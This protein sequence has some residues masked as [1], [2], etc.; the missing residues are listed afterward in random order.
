MSCVSRFLTQVNLI[1]FKNVE[2][3]NLKRPKSFNDLNRLHLM[4]F[5]T[6]RD[7]HVLTHFNQHVGCTAI[8]HVTRSLDVS[9]DSF[10]ENSQFQ[11]ETFNRF[12]SHLDGARAFRFIDLDRKSFKTNQFIT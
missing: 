3:F 4:K 6:A 7:R 10:V 8:S 2:S 9:N 11:I 12:D 1:K 5:M